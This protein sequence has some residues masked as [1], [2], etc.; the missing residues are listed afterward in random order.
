MLAYIQIPIS[1]LQTKSHSADSAQRIQKKSQAVPTESASPLQGCYLN[2]NSVAQFAH[3]N[4]CQFG[5]D[6]C[7]SKQ[8]RQPA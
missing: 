7:R 1:S 3:I 8:L 2:L 6:E 5:T 4:I